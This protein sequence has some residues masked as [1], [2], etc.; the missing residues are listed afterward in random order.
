MKFDML[1][2]D[3]YNVCKGAGSID[4]QNNVTSGVNV[5]IQ[6]NSGSK[7]TIS[8]VFTAQGGDGGISYAQSGGMHLGSLWMRLVFVNNGP[9]YINVWRFVGYTWRGL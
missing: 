1:M 5:G 4:N 6:L 9:H 8:G 3:F 2:L 7:M